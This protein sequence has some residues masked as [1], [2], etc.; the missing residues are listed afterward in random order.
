MLGDF[1]H[2]RPVGCSNQVAALYSPEDEEFDEQDEEEELT[3]DDEDQ[4]D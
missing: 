3:P 1:K 2:C 4:K